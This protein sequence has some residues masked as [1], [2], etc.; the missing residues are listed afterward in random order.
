MSFRAIGQEPAWLLEVVNE[1]HFY[2]SSNYGQQSNTYLYV[3]PQSD[4]EKRQSYFYVNN[5]LTIKIAGIECTDTMSG[6]KFESSVTIELK[7]QT[8]FGCG[9]ALF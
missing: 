9:K 2:L 4:P 1:Q 8:L 5:D 3:K 6:I 7:E